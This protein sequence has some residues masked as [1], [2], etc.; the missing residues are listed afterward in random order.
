MNQPTPC[1]ACPLRKTGAFS[2]NSEAE[3]EFIQTIKQ[4]QIQVRAGNGVM[5]EGDRSGTLYTLLSGWAFRYRTLSD[6]RRQI[7]NFLLPGDFIG[8]QHQLGQASPHGVE[9]LTD[10]TLCVFPNERLWDIYRTHP[11][12]GFDITWLSAHEE[13]IVDENLL[14]VGRRSAAERI[15]MLL[16]HLYKRAESVGLAGPDGVSFPPNQQHIADALGLSLV[17]TNKT[18]KRL[19]AMGLYTLGNGCLKLTNPVAMARLADYYA[20]PLRARPLI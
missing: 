11:G 20:L 12:L 16:I 2:A 17:H 14:S 13:L 18:L 10:A 9:A 6:G 7:F 8:L 5:R 15:A 1:S 3:I 19:Q 4:R